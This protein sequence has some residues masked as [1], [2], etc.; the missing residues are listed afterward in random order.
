[1]ARLEGASAGLVEIAAGSIAMGLGDYVA[2]KSD[3]EHYARER[4]REELE[5]GSGGGRSTGG[6]PVAR[7]HGRGGRAHRR[8]LYR[9]PE[10]WVDFMMRFDLGLDKPGPC[11]ATARRASCGRPAVE[12]HPVGSRSRRAPPTGSRAALRLCAAGVLLLAGV[13]GAGADGSRSTCFDLSGAVT[14]PLR[15]AIPLLEGRPAR[16]PGPLSFTT[17]RCSDSGSSESSASTPR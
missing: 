1:M 6:T 10:A 3:A 11:R 5:V 7:P 14:E 13:G 15:P 12:E 16:Y 9:R 8:R 17:R 2:A 4:A